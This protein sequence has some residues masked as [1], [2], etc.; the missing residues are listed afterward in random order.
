MAEKSMPWT[1]N[2]TGDGTSGG[3]T[4]LEWSEMW[5]R[6]YLA[7]QD[8]SA[9]VLRGV[10]SE[11]AVTGAA[12]PLSVGSGS[13]IVYGKM[14]TNDTALTLTVATPTVG[15]TGGH[16]ILRLD[17]SAQTVRVMA[18][19]NTDGLAAIPAL[20]QSVSTQWDIRLATF[21]IA[22]NGVVTLVD[23]RQYLHMATKISQAM[24]DAA[25]VGTA[26]LANDSVDDT[27]VGVRV[28]RF[29]RRQGGHVTTWITPGSTAYDPG[30]IIT[31]RG[32]W[33]ISVPSGVESAQE[34]ITF[35]QAFTQIPMV[36]ACLNT[37]NNGYYP[38]GVPV[39]IRVVSASTTQATIEVYRSDNINFAASTNIGL[40][41]VATG[42]E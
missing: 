36:L 34:T 38:S 39:G 3:Y 5:R 6:L 8:T 14:Y 15:A 23:A 16:V 24:I 30:M 27:K 25:A 10:G 12:S 2:G 22:T 35:P 7:G 31:Q 26:Q 13:A 20:T 4:A 28:E 33:Y 17:W 42:A 29:Y 21:T 40:V 37:L 19:R 1:G 32:S 18:I 9:G 11:L 41:W